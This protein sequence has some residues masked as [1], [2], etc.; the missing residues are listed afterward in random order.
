MLEFLTVLGLVALLVVAVVVSTVWL[1]LRRI[2]RSRLVAVGTQAVADGLPT[3]QVALVRVTLADGRPVE[4]PFT[5][6]EP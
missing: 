1:A 2:R 4:Q 3:L 6:E 5:G